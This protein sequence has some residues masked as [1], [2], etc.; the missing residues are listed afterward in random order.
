VPASAGLEGV[1]QPAVRSLEPAFEAS[2]ALRHLRMRA[3]VG[4]SSRTARMSVDAALILA[5]H[6][7][8]ERVIRS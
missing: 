6:G 1:L 8:A 3:R 4:P 5:G 2:A 7:L